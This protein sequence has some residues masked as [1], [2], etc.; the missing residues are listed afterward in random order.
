MARLRFLSWAKAAASQ[1]AGQEQSAYQSLPP[2]IIPSLYHF[3]HLIHFIKIIIHLISFDTNNTDHL[4]SS[5][6]NLL[7]HNSWT[8]SKSKSLIPETPAVPLLLRDNPGNARAGSPSTLIHLPYL[9]LLSCSQDAATSSSSRHY[10]SPTDSY[11][12]T[13]RL[14]STLHPPP[15]ELPSRHTA[16]IPPAPTQSSLTL[17]TCSNP[18]SQPSP[19]YVGPACCICKVSAF[20]PISVAVAY[21]Y[22]CASILV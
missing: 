2:S 12:L 14:L 4:I 21:L 16:F 3:I 1:L 11:S 18:K 13:A 8:S 19:P 9:P 5:F 22:T 15:F 6:T 7:S 20:Q 10:P 17:P